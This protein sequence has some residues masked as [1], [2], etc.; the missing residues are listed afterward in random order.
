MTCC[1][2]RI[3][4]P[5]E[6]QSS[7]ISFHRSSQG[8]WFSLDFLREV[9]ATFA[10]YSQ[11]SLF[12]NVFI[13]KYFITRQEMKCSIFGAL[14]SS[15][16]T[17]TSVTLYILGFKAHQ[18]DFMGC[19]HFSNI[20]KRY[21]SLLRYEYTTLRRSWVQFL[22]KAKQSYIIIFCAMCLMSSW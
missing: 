6:I 2:V 18:S 1:I 15:L 4:N 8:N 5:V 17:C 7:Y 22:W 13:C 14:Y 12:Q 16:E 10:D 3:W 11:S 19:S 20:T 9:A 21:I